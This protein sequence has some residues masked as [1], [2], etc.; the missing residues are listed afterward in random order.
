MKSSNVNNNGNFNHV[1]I[2]INGKNIK[3]S[4]NIDTKDCNEAK[5]FDRIFDTKTVDKFVVMMAIYYD[6]SRSTRIDGDSFCS[7]TKDLLANKRSVLSINEKCGGTKR[8]ICDDCGD[9]S[10]TSGSYSI[11]AADVSMD[12]NIEKMLNIF[13]NFKL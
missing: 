11:T 3:N 1:N 2:N 10:K 6:S 13:D 7:I 8:S 5:R 12:S 4:N 9:G